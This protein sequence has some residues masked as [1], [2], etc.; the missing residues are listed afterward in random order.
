[1]KTVSVLVVGGGPVGLTL[2]RDLARRG[3][4]CLLVERNPTTTSHP[5]MDNTNVRSMELFRRAGLETRLRAV[6][7]AADQPFDVSWVTTMTGHELK[8][9]AYGSPDHDRERYREINDGAQPFAPP[10]RVSQALIE[11]VLRAA[12][13]EESFAEVRFSTALTGLSEDE[14]GVTATIRNELTGKTET[15]RSLYL[16]A[17]DGGGSTARDAAGIALDGTFRIMPRFMTHFRTHDPEA[18]RLLRRWGPTW[19]YQSVHGTLIDQNAH[20]TFTLHT[21]YPANEADATRPE[22]LVARFVGREI[23][24]EIEVANPWAPHLAVARSAGTKRVLLAG[25]A[26]HQYIPTGGYGMN[27]GIGDAYG[28]AWMLAAVLHGWG[29]PALLEAYKAERMPVWHRNLEG[30]RRH[31]DVRVEM[32]KLYADS[33]LHLATPEGDIARAAA[34]V[35]IARLGNAENESLGLEMGYSYAGSP[36]M[37]DEI[38]TATPSDPVRYEPTTL[39]GC[40]LPSL[41]L[42]DGRAVYDHLGPW[43]TLLA[44]ASADVSPLED[45]AT[46][47][48]LP[49]SILRHDDA[50][51]R[52][53]YEAKLVLV[54]PDTHVAWRGNASPDPAASSALLDKLTGWS[55]SSER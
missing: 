35:S 22:Q 38:G 20:D 32:S 26:G 51:A 44:D 8:R 3:I 47:R 16:A 2:A 28:L 40:R 45:A 39:P 37:A 6:A 12:L 53:V 10:M 46:K 11:P 54:R 13:E 14:A 50:K 9:F 43:F 30:A 4:D 31:N 42:A 25:D 18:R 48:G 15:V 24:I 33:A 5:K 34:S 55:S 29:G 49:L 19:H 41:Y 17:C 23:P 36:V 1:M 7:V 21:R 52:N 27:T